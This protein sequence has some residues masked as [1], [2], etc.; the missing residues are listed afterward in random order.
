MSY[1]PQLPPTTIDPNIAQYI[2]DELRRIAD[3]Y[4][5]GQFDMIQLSVLGQEVPK[6]REGN[7]VHYAAGVVNPQ[8]GLYNFEGGQWKKL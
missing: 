4:N 3:A 7:I 8:E 5:S 6:P 2:Y 1:E